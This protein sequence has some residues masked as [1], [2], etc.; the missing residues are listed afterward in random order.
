MKL[1]AYVKNPEASEW[2]SFFLENGQEKQ[3]STSSKPLCNFN[4]IV[5][6]NLY[7]NKRKLF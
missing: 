3:G 1:K 6:E 4:Q 2:F 7:N 5:S